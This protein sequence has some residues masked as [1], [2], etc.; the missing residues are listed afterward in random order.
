M[1]VIYDSGVVVIFGHRGE[2]EDRDRSDGVQVRNAVTPDN[3]HLTTLTEAYSVLVKVRYELA[4]ALIHVDILTSWHVDI[5][6]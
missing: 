3:G 5:P 4:C 2:P 1:C 6:S